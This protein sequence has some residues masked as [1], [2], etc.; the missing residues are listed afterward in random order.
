[1]PSGVLAFLGIFLLF[2]ASCS[3]FG[4][5][6]E[7]EAVSPTDRPNIIFV[8]TDDL[9]YA[10]AQQMSE[11]RSRLIERGASFENAFVSYPLCCPSRATLLTGLY[12]HNNAVKG[13]SPPD[14]ASRSSSP[15]GTSR[16]LSL[17]VCKRLV[18]EPPSSASI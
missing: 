12:A 1:V 3:E 18:T 2:G 7:E 16:T 13:N 14:G 4:T 5:S 17:C 6:R 10:S 11:I 9:D 15:K 8:L